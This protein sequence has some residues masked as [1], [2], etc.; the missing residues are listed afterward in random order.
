MTELPLK[1]IAEQFNFTPNYL[2]KFCKDHFGQTPTEL[3]VTP[4]Q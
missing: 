4:K 1:E 2:I 3:R